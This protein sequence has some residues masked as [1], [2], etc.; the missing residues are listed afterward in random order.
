MPSKAGRTARSLEPRNAIRG[1]FPEAAF[2]VDAT[3]L[4]RF[5]GNCAKVTSWPGRASRD[6]GRISTAA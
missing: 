6:T 2:R 5:Q 1:R 4:S 3:Q